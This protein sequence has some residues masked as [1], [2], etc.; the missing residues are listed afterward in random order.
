[1]KIAVASE[2]EMVAEHFGYCEIF[3][4]FEAENGKIVKSEVIP[5]PGHMPGYLP[6]FLH[7]MGVNVMI[8]GGMGSN[9]INLFNQNGIDVITGAKGTARDVAEKYLSNELEFTGS[10]CHE[11]M[12]QDECG[13]H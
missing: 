2:R 5:N 9:A 10:V 4:I 12:H 1:M 8:S 7:E 11:H 13:K 6:I 3:T